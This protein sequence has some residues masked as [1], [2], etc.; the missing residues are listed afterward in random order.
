MVEHEKEGDVILYFIV[1][2]QVYSYK[3]LMQIPVG[4]G[5]LLVFYH[6]SKL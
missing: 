6:V 1:Y 2:F 5:D 4:L 3:V